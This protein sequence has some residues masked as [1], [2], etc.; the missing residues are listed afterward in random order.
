MSFVAQASR[1]EGYNNLNTK[2]ASGMEA[3]TVKI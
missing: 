3:T 1:R 2:Q